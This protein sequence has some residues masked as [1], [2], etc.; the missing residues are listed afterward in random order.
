MIETTL[1]FCIEIQYSGGAVHSA[2]QDTQAL[3]S[4]QK[5]T[6]KSRKGR[7]KSDN[8]RD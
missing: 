6:K 4:V 2:F 3:Q 5:Q 7:R 1:C 8:V